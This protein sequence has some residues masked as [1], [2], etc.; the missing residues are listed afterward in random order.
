MDA[1][2]LKKKKRK[3]YVCAKACVSIQF[4]EVVSAYM[5]R[6]ASMALYCNAY[7]SACRFS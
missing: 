7:N 4:L 6:L 2:I 3:V 5:C 1:K